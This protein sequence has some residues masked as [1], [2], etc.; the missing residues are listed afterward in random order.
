M[1]DENLYN[2]LEK[3]AKE[4]NIE[5]FKISAV[6]G[7]GI[8]ELLKRVSQVLKELPKEELYGL[9]DFQRIIG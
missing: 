2:D 9:M 1:Q 7:E 4:N 8:S 6:T 5:I 3:L